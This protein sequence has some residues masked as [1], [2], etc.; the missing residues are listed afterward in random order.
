MYIRGKLECAYLENNCDEE[1]IRVRSKVLLEHS[2]TYN[3]SIL[4]DKTF[5][6][7]RNIGDKMKWCKEN[8]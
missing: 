1:G 3:S 2:E 8:V 7:L 4:Y 6:K 5:N